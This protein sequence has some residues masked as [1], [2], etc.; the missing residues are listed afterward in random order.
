MRF[1]DRIAG[2][3]ICLLAWNIGYGD[4]I[5]ANLGNIVQ[6]ITTVSNPGLVQQRLQQTA[7][8]LPRSSAGLQPL[9]APEALASPAEAKIHFKLMKVNITGNTIFATATLES[10]FQPSY[11]KTISLADLQGLVNQVT[12]KYRAAGYVLSRAILPPQQIKNGIVAV[13]VIEGFISHIDVKSNNIWATKIVRKYSENILNS[14]PLQVHLLERDLLL[15]NDLPG[16]SV[17]SVITPS[18]TVPGAADLTLV[19]EKTNVNAYTSYDNYGTRYLGPLEMG[20]GASLNGVTAPGSSDG[21]QYLTVTRVN[22][23]QYIAFNHSNPFGSNGLKMNL[24]YSYTHTLSG[25]VL[26]PLDVQ[27]VNKL[28]YADVSYPWIRS[29]S[30]NF[31]LHSTFNYQ[32]V[33]STI[34]E[35]PFY[36]DLLRTLVIGGD[37]N[38]IDRFR[39]IN[40]IRLDM[41]KGFDIFGA[42][43]HLNQSRP[44]GV[45]NFFKAS[46]T[47]SRLQALPWQLSLLGAINGQYA[48]QPLLVTE[49]YS[50][51]G[52]QWGR[53][54]MPSEIVGDDGLAFKIELHR[55]SLYDKAWLQ[56]I[57]YY[58]F[59]DAGL[60]WNRDGINLP[61]KQTA[62][63][64]GVGARFTF[65]PKLTAN[66]FYAKPLTHSLS[67][68]VIM[69]KDPFKPGLFFQLVASI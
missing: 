18:K 65:L 15:M 56:G 19:T 63:S 29:R 8:R 40:D 24:G 30:E 61:P 46:L 57:Q 17:K 51:G 7:P 43:Q 32:T 10:I 6:D 60:I 44:M 45:P 27:G 41:E 39:G 3:C 2:V 9:G 5:P 16:I 35:Q 37:Y 20:V 50:Y 64:T 55:D 4:A 48:F 23:L 66:V 25:F 69:G 36:E 33:S 53:G 42:R 58:V 31:Y 49:Q 67:T 68:Q 13:Q 1:I 62:T 34:L 38:V 52:S 11:N 47:L 54:Y 22:E 14:R 26:T 12:T 21:V 28:L 59:Y